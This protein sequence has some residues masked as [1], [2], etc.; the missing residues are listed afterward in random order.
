MSKIH[1][2]ALLALAENRFLNTFKVLKLNTVIACNAFEHGVKKLFSHLTLQSIDCRNDTFL[3]FVL[4]EKDV[5]KAG[6]AFSEDKKRFLT[7]SCSNDQIHFMMTR[8][9]SIINFNR[10]VFYTLSFKLLMFTAWNRGISFS[11]FITPHG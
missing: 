3:C 4:N 2:C 8:F 7:P 10:A 6:Y 11:P 1:S 9:F 5:L